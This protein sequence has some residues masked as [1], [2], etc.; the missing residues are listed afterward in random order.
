[1]S[2]ENNLFIDLHNQMA[3]KLDEDWKVS[4]WKIVEGLVTFSD[5]LLN[6]WNEPLFFYFY[7][8][9]VFK[10]I[11]DMKDKVI[12][13]QQESFGSDIWLDQIKPEDTDRNLSLILNIVDNN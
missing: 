11:E 12:Y 8:E 3:D 1:M 9:N 13:L 2:W 7:S 6:W 10:V 4:K 5:T